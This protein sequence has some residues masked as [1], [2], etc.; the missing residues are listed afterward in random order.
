MR[1]S[2]LIVVVIIVLAGI[3]MVFGLDIYTQK[4][5]ETLQ[6]Q[7]RLTQMFRDR[8]EVRLDSEVRLRWENQEPGRKGQGLKVEVTPSDAV[9]Q[10]E[11]GLRAFARTIV[12]EAPAAFGRVGDQ[13]EWIRIRV[14]FPDKSQLDA[15]LVRGLEG[16]FGDADP[17]FPT[18][19]PEPARTP[20]R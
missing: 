2:T 20:P 11:Q 18:R 5:R 9:L 16:A 15:W 13:L 7:Q 17:P 8:G 14:F 10:R 4:D 19:W 12:R 1:K 6:I 3:A